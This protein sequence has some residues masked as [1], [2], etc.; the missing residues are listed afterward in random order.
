MPNKQISLLERS[1]IYIAIVDFIESYQ[2]SSKTTA[3][4]ATRGVQISSISDEDIR[5]LLPVDTIVY[6]TERV[7]YWSDTANAYQSAGPFKVDTKTATFDDITI[8]VNVLGMTDIKKMQKKIDALYKLLSQQYPE[9]EK[10]LCYALI[11]DKNNL[12][13]QERDALL[14]VKNRNSELFLHLFQ[15]Y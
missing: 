15:N 9:L 14:K 13:F 5:Q 7:S 4:T 11:Y 6:E 2:N 10:M 1:P 12:K 8:K 3:S